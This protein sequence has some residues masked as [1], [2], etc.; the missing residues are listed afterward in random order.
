MEASYHRHRMGTVGGAEACGL[1]KGG[2]TPRY[3]WPWMR[4]VCQSDSL[5]F[6][7]VYVDYSALSC[8]PRRDV[9]CRARFPEGAS[10]HNPFEKTFGRGVA[11]AEDSEVGTLS[12]IIDAI[13]QAFSFVQDVGKSIVNTTADVVRTYMYMSWRRNSNGS[14]PSNP[15]KANP[16]TTLTRAP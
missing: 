9:S 11:M 12:A 5:P 7:F 3:I 6:S 10:A 13:R 2:R 8:N 14:K 15:G 1:T 16:L 4:V